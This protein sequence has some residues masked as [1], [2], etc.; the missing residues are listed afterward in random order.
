MESRQGRVRKVRALYYLCPPPHLQ[1]Y[2]FRYGYTLVGEMNDK[3]ESLG[4]ALR[5]LQRR[6]SLPETGELDKTTLEAM[7]TPRCGVP[8][9]GRFQTFEGNLKWHHQDITYWCAAGPRGGGG[10][11]RESQTPRRQRS[12]P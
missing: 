1:E 12:R 3:E 4:S 7:R 8:D 2:L 5:L 10:G 11:G 6:L 9:L